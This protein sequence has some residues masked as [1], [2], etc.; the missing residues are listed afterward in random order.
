MKKI[1][2]AAFILATSSSAFAGEY[3]GDDTLGWISGYQGQPTAYNVIYNVAGQDFIAEFYGDNTMAFINSP[4][5]QH[6]S[7]R[8]VGSSPSL[9]SLDELLQ[10][11]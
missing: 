4:K 10:Q 5:K 8:F 2:I 1:F 3:Q 11:G 9:S 6:F 7:L